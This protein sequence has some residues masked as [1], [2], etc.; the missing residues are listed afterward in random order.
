MFVISELS[1]LSFKDHNFMANIITRVWVIKPRF[2][3]LEI[4]CFTD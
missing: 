4:K 2:S 1:T 3:G